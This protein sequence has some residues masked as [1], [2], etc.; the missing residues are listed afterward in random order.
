MIRKINTTY[1]VGS[2]SD[3]CTGINYHCPALPEAWVPAS[4]PMRSP[5]LVFFT[6]TRIVKS[7]VTGQAPVTLEL[8]NTLGKSTKNPKW[9]THIS[10]LTQ[11]T[12]PQKHIKEKSRVSLRCARSIPVHGLRLITRA[13]KNRLYRLPPKEDHHVYISRSIYVT[14]RNLGSEVWSQGEA[15]EDIHGEADEGI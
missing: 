3:L 12:P 15:C 6:L 2:K 7:V 8:R 1:Q 11:F 13:W 5:C 4:A 10:Q 14:N 9:Y